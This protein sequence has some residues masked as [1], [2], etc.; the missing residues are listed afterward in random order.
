MA[1]DSVVLPLSTRV[2]TSGETLH[3]ILQMTKKKP[4]IEIP[5][6]MLKIDKIAWE[7]WEIT[8]QRT[9][10]VSVQKLRENHE[11][12]QQLTSRLQQMQEQMN[13]MNGS[14]RFSRCGI[15]L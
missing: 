7:L 5:I 15:K 13:S 4:E 10:E 14:G 12:I 9:D 6:Q 1:F 11:T 8:Q 3:A 2:T